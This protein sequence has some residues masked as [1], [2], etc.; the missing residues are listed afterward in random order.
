MASLTGEFLVIDLKWC[1]GLPWTRWPSVQSPSMTSVRESYH[2]YQHDI[3]ADIRKCIAC[4][5]PKTIPTSM[6]LIRTSFIMLIADFESFTLRLKWCV[7]DTEIITGPI[8]MKCFEH[9]RNEKRISTVELIGSPWWITLLLRKKLF[10]FLKFKVWKNWLIVS[11]MEPMHYWF[12][13]I[14]EHIKIHTTCQI[15]YKFQE[16]FFFYP[17]LSMFDS[18]LVHRY[19]DACMPT[20]IADSCKS[21]V[22]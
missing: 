12:E 20:E 7:F 9:A 19:I 10:S 6:H 15:N 8:Y 5:H 4:V 18:K 14:Y 11:S 22:L 21:F 13:K 1:L 2:L 16:P 17:F 3:C